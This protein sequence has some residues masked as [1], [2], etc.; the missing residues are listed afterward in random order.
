[1][2]EP[3]LKWAGGKRW[4]TS[5]CRDVFPSSYRRY[6]EPF[7][8]SGAVFFSLAPRE[9]ILSDI[10]GDL[11]DTYQ[12]I[13]IDWQRVYS[14]LK[15]HH[16]YHS[17]DYY[18]KIRLSRP[19]SLFARSARFIYLNRTCWNGLYRVNLKGQ[20]NVPIGSKTRVIMENDDFKEVSK[21]LQNVHILKSDFEPVIDSTNRDD[22][23][24]VDP[25]YTVKHSDNGFIKYNEQ[26]FSWDDQIRLSEC[27]KRASSRGVRIVLT[28]APHAS[29]YQLY[30][31]GF[32]C[33]KAVRNSVIA[34]ASSKRKKCE[35]LII[36]NRSD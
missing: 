11:I 17:R 26:L 14:L 29:I 12:A 31:V 35:E 16:N 4:L 27:L 20:F 24:F 1:M 32:K 30:T 23:L 33:S 7:L 3:F 10:N 9:A 8:G 34:A 6:V 5:N 18:Y 2:L 15:E 25:P 13:K 36:T 22:L 21:R 19:R 28:N